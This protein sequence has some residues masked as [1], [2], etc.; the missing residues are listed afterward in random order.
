MV[1]LTVSGHPGS[2]TST[3]V[4]GLVE[5]LGWTSLNGGQVFREEA[6]RRGMDLAAFGDL[7]R[8]DE[9]VDRSLDAL[10]QE[11]MALEGGPHI[12]ESRMAGWWGHRLDLPCL[13]VWLKADDE[14]R[15]ARVVDREGGSLDDAKEANR[16]RMEVDGAR[17]MH[18]YGLDPEDPTP[19]THVLDVSEQTAEEVL[20]AV[21]SLIEE[22][23]P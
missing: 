20:A 22:A 5:H 6:R 10:L 2:G 1:H 12:V 4:E 16:R 17:F 11:Q 23:T 7:C 18:L 9:A 8:D 13:R 15:A 14:A 3:L 21:L 19:Y